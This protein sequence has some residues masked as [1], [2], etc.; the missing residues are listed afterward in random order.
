[1]SC[2]MSYH[3]TSSSPRS[4]RASSVSV[5]DLCLLEEEG[6]GGGGK[7]IVSW[8]D[9]G[10]GFVVWS[11][12]EF[13]ELTCLDISSTIIFLALFANLIHMGFKKTSSRRWEFKHDKFRRDHQHHHHIVNGM[14]DETSVH[15][16]TLMEENQ[17]L[18]REKVELQ[19]Q[20]AQFKAL[21]IKLLDC[22]DQHTKNHMKLALL[23]AF[24]ASFD[25]HNVLRIHINIKTRYVL[26]SRSYYTNRLNKAT[27]YSRISPLGSPDKSVEAEL[28]DGSNMAT[29]FESPSFNASFTIFASEN[30]SLRPFSQD[31]FD[32]ITANKFPRVVSEWMNRKGLCAFSPTEHA[33]QLDLIGKVQGFASAEIYFNKLKDQDKTDKTYGA[34]LNCYVRQRQTDRGMEGILTEMENQPHIEMDWNTYAVAANL[35]ELEEAE[36]VL[37]EWESSGNCYDLRIPN[38]VVVGDEGSVH[39]AE[40]FVET[41]RRKIPVSEKCIMPC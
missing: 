28:E 30:A 31:R 20:I 6:G 14:D 21:Q 29:T 33:V 15:C 11:P 5:Q 37:E 12:A 16:Q 41:L 19:T 39:D 38:I 32:I 23:V 8:N 17:H 7:K 34:L 10:T 3:P 1:M 13:S 40:E 2:E 18:R 22:L 4:K 9:E 24:L 35:D 27:L 26:L 25:Q 36:K